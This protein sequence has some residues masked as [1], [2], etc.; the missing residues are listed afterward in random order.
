M[1]HRIDALCIVQDSVE[2]W[3]NESSQMA[4]IYESGYFNISATASSSS[5]GGL[6]RSTARF[7]TVSYQNHQGESISVVPVLGE[8]PRG[9]FHE[10]SLPLLSRAWVL[11][12]RLLCRRNVHFLW[13]EIGWQCKS[14]EWTCECELSPK[15]IQDQLR[16]LQTPSIKQG[17]PLAI[18]DYW[19]ELV[20]RYTLLGLT[21]GD[22]KLPA[23]SGLAQATRRFAAQHSLDLGQYH[24]GIWQFGIQHGLCWMVF[25]GDSGLK[26][27]SGTYRAPSWSWAAYDTVIRVQDLRYINQSTIQAWYAEVTDVS[28]MLATLDTHGKVKD[29]YLDLATIYFD[30]IIEPGANWKRMRFPTV[31]SIPEH[32]SPLVC[33]LISAI[34]GVQK[35]HYSSNSL[36]VRW[37]ANVSEQIHGGLRCTCAI[38][39]TQLR[40]SLD[41]QGLTRDAFLMLLLPSSWH[42]DGY[43]RV[44]CF[45]MTVTQDDE[46]SAF[47]TAWTDVLKETRQTKRIY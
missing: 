4:R 14:V 2:D 43:V 35:T 5:R 8:P 24:A 16:E 31:R 37:D 7:P 27:M 38:M 12:E 11:Q 9:L 13:N 36:R 28:C 47:F 40:K 1:N 18:L 25:S 6:F 44:G 3:A 34:N 41:K 15:W 33:T 21:Q 20:A 10:K 17:S 29:G 39:Y 46:D 26:D 45:V 22:D 23:M 30:I 32:N 19:H 42:S